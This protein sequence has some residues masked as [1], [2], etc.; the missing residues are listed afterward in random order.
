MFV[1]RR[2]QASIGGG[3]QLALGGADRLVAL[4]EERQDALAQAEAA[5]AL[6]ALRGGGG[7]LAR[8]VLS[9]V[10]ASDA[11]LVVRPD[12]RVGLAGWQPA[13]ETPFETARFT[14]VDLETTGVGVDRPH[15]RD[16]RRPR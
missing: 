12:G 1:Q 13:R 5:S 6:L 11:R 4:L 2:R 16:R 9:E 8:K 3:I 14:V 15:P 10:V 7:E